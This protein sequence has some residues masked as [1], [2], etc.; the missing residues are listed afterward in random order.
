MAFAKSDVHREFLQTIKYLSTMLLSGGQV[1][2]KNAFSMLDS[3]EF[4]IK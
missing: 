2:L 4:G 3:L 1:G